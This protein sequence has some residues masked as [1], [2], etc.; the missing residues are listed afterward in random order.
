MRVL[1]LIHSL[2]NLIHVRTAIDRNK[3]KGVFM[4]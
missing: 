3:E 2:C 1:T 4:L